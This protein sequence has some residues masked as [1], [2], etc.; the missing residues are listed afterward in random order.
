MRS[1]EQPADGALP[2]ALQVRV[3]IPDPKSCLRHLCSHMREHGV[4]VQEDDGVFTV[5]LPNVAGSL[6]Q[7]GRHVA[8]DAAAADLDA[9]YFVKMWLQ[10]EFSE[11]MSNPAPP[12][13]WNEGSRNLRLPPSFRTL[14]VVAVRDVTPRMRRITFRG[15]GIEHFDTLSALHL[16]ILVNLGDIVA[17]ERRHGVAAARIPEISQVIPVWRRYTVRSVDRARG[18][19]DVDFFLHGSRGP[20]TSWARKARPGDMAGAAGPS[21]GGIAKASWYL[22][23]GDETAL[24]AISRILEGLPAT[25]RGTVAIEVDSDIERQELDCPSGMVVEWIN[26]KMGA[27]ASRRNLLDAVEGADFPPQG[28]SRFAW[29]GCEAGMAKKIRSHLHGERALTKSEHLV[30][31]FWHGDGDL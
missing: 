8:V 1:T 19:I 22:L 28:D 26:R 10:A 16:Q 4:D 9:L 31:A 14:A 24:P 29:V 20:G 23:A 18:T 27:T 6:R 3:E 21:G 5:I 13:E 15:N 2:Y 17:Q 25:A 7:D 30:V 12:I 11:L